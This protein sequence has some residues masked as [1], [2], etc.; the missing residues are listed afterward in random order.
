MPDYKRLY[1]STYLLKLILPVILFGILAFSVLGN[2]SFP[3]LWNDE[4]ETAMFGRLILK[5]GYPKVHDGK[6]VLNLSEFGELLIDQKTDSYLAMMW[7]QYFLAAIGVAWSQLTGDIYLK[8]ALVRLPF[9]LVGIAGIYLMAR[10]LIHVIKKDDGRIRLFMLFILLE[11]ISVPLALHLREARYYSLTVFLTAVILCLSSRRSI[12]MSVGL[13][14]YWLEMTVL[15][16][17]IFNTFSPA[18]WASLLTLVSWVFVRRKIGRSVFLDLVPVGLSLLLVLPTAT[19]FRTFVQFQSIAG[20]HG[21]GVIKYV[22]NIEATV[23]FFVRYDLLIFYAFLKLILFFSGIY[24]NTKKKIA[25]TLVQPRFLSELLFIFLASYTAVIGLIPYYLF[26]RY[27]IPMQPVLTAAVAIDCYLV[28]RITRGWFHSQST[29]VIFLL[30]LLVVSLGIRGFS[31]TTEPIKGHIYE[32]TH[33]Y[34]G[35]I[36]DVILYLANRFKNPDK[37]IIA[38]NYEEHAYIFYLGS[39]T[40]IGFVGNNLENDLKENPDIIIPRRNWGHNFKELTWFLS[41]GQYELISFPYTDLAVNNIPEIRNN[42]GIFHRY[43][44]EITDS[45]DEKIKVFVRSGAK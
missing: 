44:T 26:E 36:D 31:N 37:L 41:R 29:G 45:E 39:K 5:F 9:A 23:D 6:N 14:L 22:T 42:I 20:T 24:G 34:K 28:Y 43:K 40:I 2:L 11:L 10:T 35:P 33:V 17:L 8:T 4:A 16:Y 13:K 1:S 38:T 7:G 12:F 15:L 3:L 25:V 27:I 19:F 32:L 21:I 30:I 18:Y